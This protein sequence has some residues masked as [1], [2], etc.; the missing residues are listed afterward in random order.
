MSQDCPKR[1]RNRM[2]ATQAWRQLVGERRSDTSPIRWDL[3]NR[4]RAEIAAGIYDTPQKFA[5][6]LERMSLSLLA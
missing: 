2:S 4:V 3:V 6:A 1:I 5:A